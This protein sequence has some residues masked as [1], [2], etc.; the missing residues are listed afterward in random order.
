MFEGESSGYEELIS[1]MQGQVNRGNT[2]ALITK[3]RQ[4]TA[5]PSLVSDLTPEDPIFMSAKLARLTEMLGEGIR[6]QQQGVDILRISCH[7]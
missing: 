2:L 3:L 4:F 6:G 1:R 7:E 5:H